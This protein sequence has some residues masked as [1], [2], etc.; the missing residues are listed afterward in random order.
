MAELTRA[1][2]DGRSRRTHA[3][4]AVMGHPTRIS[5]T[6]RLS[7][8]IH[9]AYAPRS[10]PC[11][12][13]RGGPGRRRPGLQRGGAG[14]E[15]RGIHRAC[16][17]QVTATEAAQV[18]SVFDS[19]RTA[20]GFFPSPP[21]GTLESVLNHFENMGKHADFIL[22][23]PNLPWEDFHGGMDAHPADVENYLRLYREVY[24][25]VKAEAPGTQLF[26]TFQWDDLNNM[27][28]SAAEGRTPRQVNWDQV[29][30]FEPR[31]DLWVIS[32]YPYFAFPAA[33][34]DPGRRAGSG[35][36]PASDP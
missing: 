18:A 15:P 4:V 34:P 27:F 24:D 35:C 8:G 20:Y 13:L 28:A 12:R 23:Q 33:G 3:R 14:G 26:V 17:A 25:R 36:L 10:T 9:D 30:A 29:E 16:A 22:I 11:T 5:A 6:F 21:E 19:G 2:E 1:R 7:P 31:L 32:S